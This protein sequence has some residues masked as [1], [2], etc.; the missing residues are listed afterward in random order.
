MNITLCQ[1]VFYKP[2]KIYFISFLHPISGWQYQQRLRN[3]NLVSHGARWSGRLGH[4]LWAGLEHA[5]S[6]ASRRWRLLLPPS[7][8][9]ACKQERRQ[10]P[11]GGR[12]REVCVRLLFGKRV[13][14]DVFPKASPSHPDSVPGPGILSRYVEEEKRSLPVPALIVMPYLDWYN[15][16]R[17]LVSQCC[18]INVITVTEILFS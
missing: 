1:I 2:V 11:E 13:F 12:A 10:C 4:P 15:D 8:K 3:H 17:D 14:R 5:G 6:M 18:R 16:S 9:M 7:E